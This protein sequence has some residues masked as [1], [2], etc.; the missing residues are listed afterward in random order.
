[1]QMVVPIRAAQRLRSGSGG[2]NCSCIEQYG[3]AVLSDMG[4][5]LAET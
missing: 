4:S 1:M 2:R 3:S 5:Q